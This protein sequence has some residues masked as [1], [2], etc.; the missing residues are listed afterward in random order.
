MLMVTLNLLILLQ[1]PNTAIPKGTLWA[2]FWTTL[3]YV[4]LTLTSGNYLFFPFFL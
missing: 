4:V 3:S 2:I 1:D